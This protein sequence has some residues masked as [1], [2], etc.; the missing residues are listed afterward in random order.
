MTFIL[1]NCSATV[2]NFVHP[3]L[4]YNNNTFNHLQINQYNK[5]QRSLMSSMKAKNDFETEPRK[6]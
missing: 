5:Q 6:K 3:S 1:K 4:L 2:E